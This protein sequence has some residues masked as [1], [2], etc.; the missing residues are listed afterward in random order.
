MLHLKRA[1]NAR[2]YMNSCIEKAKEQR[3]DRKLG[4]NTP[5]SGP[6]YGHYSFDFAQQVSLDSIAESKLSNYHILIHAFV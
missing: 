3:G 4:K 1:E 6:P 2:L 5:C